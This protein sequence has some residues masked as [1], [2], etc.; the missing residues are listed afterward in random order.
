MAR[1]S[2]LT[3]KML[4]DGSF[5]KRLRELPEDLREIV[6]DV[7]NDALNNLAADDLFGTECQLDPRG[8]LR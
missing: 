2:A 7:L 4:E 1:T 3:L 8:D 5:A 6:L